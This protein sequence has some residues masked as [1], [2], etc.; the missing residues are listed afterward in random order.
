MALSSAF[1]EADFD[2]LFAHE[3]EGKEDGWVEAKQSAVV[4]VWKRTEKADSVPTVKA[5]QF[6]QGIP[7]QTMFDLLNL[8]EERLKWDSRTKVF[9]VLESEGDNSTMQWAIHLPGPLVKNR[10]FV[11]SR[12]I[13]KD[14]KEMVTL[15]KS[16][17]HPDAPESSNYIRGEVTGGSILRPDEEDP[18]STRVFFVSKVDMKGSLPGFLVNFMS[19]QAPFEQLDN[20]TKFCQKTSGKK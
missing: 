9:K 17:T 18:N 15:I 4:K 19:N 16:T 12:I 2:R 3:K 10:E 6:Y 1:T 5:T 8:P 20:I 14:A 13:R 7:V 11:L